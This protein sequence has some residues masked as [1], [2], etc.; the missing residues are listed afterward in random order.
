MLELAWWRSGHGSPVLIA[1]R[2]GRLH[3]PSWVL[4]FRRGPSVWPWHGRWLPRHSLRRV[5]IVA[6]AWALAAPPV[7]GSL[8]GPLLRLVLR[9]RLELWLLVLRRLWMLLGLLRLRRL[10]EVRLL[11]LLGLLGLLGL[12][13]L[14][15]LLE[16]R[17]LMLLGL[18]RLLWLS[19]LLRAL[20]GLRL[21]VS[22]LL[23]P[24]A[25]MIVI[26]CQGLAACQPKS[27]GKA[28][29]RARGWPIPSGVNTCVH[30]FLLD[31]QRWWTVHDG[32]ACPKMPARHNAKSTLGTTHRRMS[33]WVLRCLA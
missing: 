13:R 28:N 9:R 26:V 22:P 23:A 17:L 24:G 2:R 18:L 11:M 25:I 21:L 5:I 1:R 15:R 14:L 4:R 8:L 12:R 32:Q 30:E 27:Q 3:G 20:R 29:Q 19:G 6:L 10:L 7:L 31:H 16:M 33:F